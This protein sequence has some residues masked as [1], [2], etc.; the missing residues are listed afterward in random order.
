VVTTANKGR[1]NI[2]T[3]SWHMMM[4]F[5]PPRIGCIIGPWDYSFEAL[6]VVSVKQMVVY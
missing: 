1:T 5:N 3:M 4:E 2:M 6:L